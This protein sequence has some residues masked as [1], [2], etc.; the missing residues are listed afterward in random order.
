MKSY[1]LF[2]YSICALLL[3]NEGFPINNRDYS[4]KSTE[5]GYE[6]PSPIISSFL[7]L[8]G[9]ENTL[10]TIIGSNFNDVVTVEFDG[11]ASSAFNII[12]DNEITVY[13]PSG[14]SVS[15]NIS[16]TSSGGCSGNASSDFSLI[17]S[18]CEASDVYISEIYDSETGSPGIIELYNPTNTMLVF[19]GLYE[20]QRYGNIGD[21][22]PSI[23]L[24]LPN[25]IGPFQTY[26]VKI[27][28]P[29]ACGLTEDAEMGAGINDNDEFNLLKS[30]W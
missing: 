21:A 6:C 26:L 18:E 13:V 25:S 5:I 7:P 9:P 4:I 19:A 8:S 20:L 29:T 2:I 24:I 1:F 14:L 10:V 12:N 11:I 15:A 16:M 30:G 3:F 22:A 17:T 28:G 23:T 27:G